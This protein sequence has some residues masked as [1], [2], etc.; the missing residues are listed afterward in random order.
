M[1]AVKQHKWIALFTRADRLAQRWLAK[2][3]SPPCCQR[4]TNR[5]CQYIV[6][7]KVTLWAASYSGCVVYNFILYRASGR[8]QKKK[9]IFMRYSGTNSR[10]KRPISRKFRGNFRGQFRW[11]TI[12]KEWPISWELPEQISLESDWFCADLR[13]VF[14]ETRRFYSISSGFIPQYEIVL[15][16]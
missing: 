12:G 7:N 11:K 9:S 1:F 13:K 10:K 15:Y 6:T 14:N 16:K 4:K 8:L 5:F 3:Y 2:Y